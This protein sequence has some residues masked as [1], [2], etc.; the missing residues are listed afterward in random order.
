M[1]WQPP[2]ERGRWWGTL[3]QVAGFLFA[4]RMCV[5]ILWCSVT[6]R[7]GV[8]KTISIAGWSG[9]L[10]STEFTHE[11]ADVHGDDSKDDSG[12]G[13]ALHGSVGAMS[14]HG[15][16]VAMSHRSYWSSTSQKKSTEHHVG[17]RRS[18]EHDAEVRSTEHDAGE[19]DLGRDGHRGGDGVLDKDGHCGG[20]SM[21]AITPCPHMAVVLLP[22]TSHV[23]PR[24]PEKHPPSLT[25]VMALSAHIDAAVDTDRSLIQ[26]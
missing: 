5:I 2:I 21:A 25:R 16:R 11:L 8:V 3:L 18:S 19:G 7:L 12:G 1:G 13:S 6:A 22:R 23:R 14:T 24:P 20:A 15:A 26:T 10:S 9:T 17:S 4:I